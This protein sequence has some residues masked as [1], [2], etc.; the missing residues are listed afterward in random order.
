MGQLC[1]LLGIES[2]DDTNWNIFTVSDTVEISAQR[3]EKLM[4]NWV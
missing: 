3:P 1:F 2:E 4:E